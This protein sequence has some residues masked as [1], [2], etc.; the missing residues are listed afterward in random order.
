[1]IGIVTRCLSVTWIAASLGGCVASVVD[2]YIE[3]EIREIETIRVVSVDQ[4]SGRDVLAEQLGKPEVVA[5]D[6]LEL[7]VHPLDPEKIAA[8]QREAGSARSGDGGAAAAAIVFTLA[9]ETLMFG[10]FVLA[11]IGTAVALDASDETRDAAR[12]D[13]AVI[14]AYAP[15]GDY[16][17]QMCCPKRTE[18]DAFG[19]KP[20]FLSEPAA[21]P[22]DRTDVPEE[23]RRRT[24]AAYN[25]DRWLLICERA[26]SGEIAAQSVLEYRHRLYVLD[27]AET[28]YWARTRAESIGTPDALAN[29]ASLYPEDVRK[30]GEILH[31]RRPLSE[32]DC[33]ALA[34]RMT[35]KPEIAG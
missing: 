11:D 29:L 17:W 1:M 8:L 30:K 19:P 23:V 4:P 2:D 16:R 32:V 28:Y 10:P 24:E 12:A 20:A 22:K 5:F 35:V 3:E 15:D 21:W 13:R 34:D 18:L 31:A 33:R 9:L 14:F 6:D 26:K 25:P 27:A 7:H